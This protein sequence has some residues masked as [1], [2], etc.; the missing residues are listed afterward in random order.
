MVQQSPAKTERFLKAINKAAMEK[1]TDIAKQIEESTKLEMQ[2][3]EDEARKDGHAKIDNAK[4]KIQAK[5]KMTVATYHL[6]K[7]SDIYAKRLAYQNMIFDDA[8]EQLCTF[9]K[10]DK[11]KGFIEK[12]A[13]AISHRVS[14]NPTVLIAEAD[15]AIKA[16]VSKYIG[17]AAFEIDPTIEIGGLRV[18]DEKSGI[19][20]DD[21]LD[22]R[23]S[24]QKDWFLNNA[25]M[26]V[27]TE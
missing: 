6:K 3:A 12:S 27:E 17:T 8:R 19:M 16:T 25:D 18:K 14:D 20:I 15:S 22:T 13:E 2:K 7:R 21:T 23:L 5:A 4:A 1:C 10:S 24:E 26:R 9:A 11:Y